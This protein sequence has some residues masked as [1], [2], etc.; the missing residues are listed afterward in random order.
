VATA[1]KR[2]FRSDTA[3]VK[4]VR[5]L[6]RELSQHEPDVERSAE[7]ALAIAM[8]KRIDHPDTSAAAAASCGRVMRGAIADLRALMPD[9]Q[10]S[11][12][13]DQLAKRIAD[14]MAAP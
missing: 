8:A 9:R 3:T 7:A 14:R 12:P 2:A 4:A 11:D 1:K 10:D 13:L 5:A 6:I